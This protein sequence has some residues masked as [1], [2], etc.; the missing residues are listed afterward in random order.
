ML[1]ARIGEIFL[2]SLII[3][4]FKNVIVTKGLKPACVEV[5]PVNARIFGDLNDPASDVSVFIRSHR[6]SVLKAWTGNGPHVFYNGID[7][8]VS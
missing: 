8:E 6:V 7:A 4:L 1:E 5:C 3:Y 2:N